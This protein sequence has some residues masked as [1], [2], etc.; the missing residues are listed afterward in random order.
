[1][2]IQERKNNQWYKGE[3]LLN[4]KPG[5]EIVKVSGASVSAA[6]LA[7][8]CAL[9]MQW[10]ITDGNDYKMYATKLQTY[11]IRGV[12]KREGDIYPNRQWGYGI[13]DVQE[14][15]NSLINFK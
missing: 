1:M 12:R 15:F 8:C 9:I 11:L 14:I 3:T 4:P 13:L 6:V 2:N 10:A 5:G 7:G